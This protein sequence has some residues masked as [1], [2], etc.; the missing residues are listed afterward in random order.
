MSAPG[1]A[2]LFTQHDLEF[3]YALL[4]TECHE[5]GGAKDIDRCDYALHLALKTRGQLKNIDKESAP[6]VSL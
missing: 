2:L 5:A 6:C 3:I 4:L 1:T